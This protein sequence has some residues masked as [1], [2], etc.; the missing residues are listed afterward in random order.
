MSLALTADG[1]IKIWVERVSK[2]YPRPNGE[3]VTAVARADLF[4]RTGE[5]LVILGP[6]GCGK[7]TLLRILAGLEEPTTGNV[8]VDGVSVTGP[9]N[10]RG[11]VFQA[12]T[13]FP[14]LTVAENIAFGLRLRGNDE[15]E[16]EEVVNQ[17]LDVTGLLDSRDKYPK[18]LSGGMKQRVAIA[19]TL[20][21]KPQ[22]LLMDEPFGALD[23]EARWRM[24]E[25]LLEIW[26]KTRVTVVFVTHDIEEALFLADTVY[27]STA[28]PSRQKELLRVPL[29]RPRTLATKGLQEFIE[30]EMDIA[31]MIRAEGGTGS[32]RE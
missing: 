19:R 15:K 3:V 22:V 29:E 10:D 9:G 12:Y 6:S 14:W 4:V 23:A 1:E 24:H 30:L 27:V 21:T 31:R 26:A 17:Y 20:A 7:T 25:L 16:R 32:Q 13:S 8:F 2:T 18:E 11:M 28:R 5:F